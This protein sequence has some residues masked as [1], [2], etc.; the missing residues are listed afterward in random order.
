MSSTRSHDDLGTQ[1]RKGLGPV[2]DRNIAALVERRQA[3]RQ[4]AS[5]QDRCA[6]AITAFAGS[7]TFVYL[8]A[9]IFGAWIV[10]NRGWL[11]AIPAWDPSYVMLA[12]VASVEAI[13][14]STFVLITQNRMATAADQ[15]ADL[16]LQISLLTE[17]ELTR[18]AR[19]VSDIASHLNISDR[20]A[21]EIEE[22]K[23][24]VAPEAV[25]DH[26]ERGHEE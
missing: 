16:D 18:V 25:L 15:R 20:A 23:E 7:M 10:V 26:I 6:D 12:M 17:H 14:L 21:D 24:D 19:L 2:L 22:V 8:H 11:P 1:P 9:A 5:F 13:F 4:A 3:G